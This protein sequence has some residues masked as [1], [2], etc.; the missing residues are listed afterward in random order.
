MT[1]WS[2]KAVAPTET[3][4]ENNEF[5]VL[6]FN[7]KEKSKPRTGNPGSGH[8]TGFQL[9]IFLGPIPAMIICAGSGSAVGCA[10]GT[11]VI[12]GCGGVD[13]ETREN[14]QLGHD[15]NMWK[16]VK[17][18]GGK[19][20]LYV[21]KRPTECWTAVCWQSWAQSGIFPQD[22]LRERVSLGTSMELLL[23][24]LM[25][26][27]DVSEAYP[28]VGPDNNGPMIRNDQALRMRQTWAASTWVGFKTCVPWSILRHMGNGHSFHI[29]GTFNG[30][31]K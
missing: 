17:H 31:M 3:W 23:V 26:S 11:P 16:V 22:R 21:R 18:P 29:L 19:V 5:D 9:Q 1:Q 27:Y 6:M 2:C 8:Q 7:F 25:K 14:G 15:M 13:V 20:V 24:N 12:L 4:H 30:W 28:T 10:V